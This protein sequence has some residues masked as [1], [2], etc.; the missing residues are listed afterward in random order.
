MTPANPATRHILLCGLVGG[1]LIAALKWMEYRFLILEHSFEIY[2]ALVAALFA[3]FGIWLGNRLTRHPPAPAPQIIVKEVP[4][5]PVAFLPTEGRREQLG[6]TRA[7]IRNPRSSSPRA[8]AIARSPTSS[9]SARTPSRPTA[10][11]P[12]TS[13]AHAAAPRPS[14]S[15][16]SSACS[17]DRTPHP[18]A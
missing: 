3:G 16:K 12:S 15:A 11:A 17:A 14:S 2:G 4:A 10:A 18:N 13:W 5:P 8:S 9:S 6:L 1:L 7:R